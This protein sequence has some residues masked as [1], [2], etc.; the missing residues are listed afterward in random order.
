MLKH[1]LGIESI[2]DPYL[3]IAA[4]VD[5]SGLV[6]VHDL[7]EL[8]DIIVKNHFQITTGTNW[9]F[10]DAA[11]EFPAGTN[12]MS[13]PLP[14]VY[15]ISNF[16]ADM[17]DLDFIG[18]KSGDLSG[19]ANY[20]SF[21]SRDVKVR[22]APLGLLAYDSPLSKGDQV[23]IRISASEWYGIAGYQVGLS[24]DPE[25]ARLLGAEGTAIGLSGQQPLSSVS[26]NGS[27]VAAIW[28]DTAPLQS[29]VNTLLR[30]R[31]EALADTRVSEILS[32]SE[33][34][35]RPEAYSES[36][37]VIDLDLQFTDQ[38]SVTG[39][40][41]TTDQVLV[42]G[43]SFPNPFSN[44]TRIPVYSG[45]EFNARIDVFD[46]SGRVVHSR[47]QNLLSG[48]NQVLIS[49]TDLAGTGVFMV[50]ITAGDQVNT[51]RIV[52]QTWD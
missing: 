25:K 19:E 8:K 12:P 36:Y 5:Q 18:V 46:A 49:A 13:E 1:I 23:E 37:D 51:V 21:G 22:S 11:A 33:S 42:V 7:L 41:V 30:I 16:T 52:S 50:R 27:S 4:D 17:T 48:Q 34:G 24:V 43:E 39:T 15:T 32:L 26:V 45:S 20:P 29:G 6:N 9:Q 44:I 47:L 40:P 10:V 28:F 31:V 3:Y 35:A 2:N 14:T 38:P